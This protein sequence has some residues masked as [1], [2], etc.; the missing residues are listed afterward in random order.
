M[1]KPRP[2]CCCVCC[3]YSG[4]WAGVS[5]LETVDPSTSLTVRPFHGQL[6]GASCLS[7]WPAACARRAPMSSGHRPRALHNCRGEANRAAPLGRL[8]RP[9]PRHGIRAGP[10]RTQDLQPKGPAG[11][12]RRTA[13][14]TALSLGLL[15]D[16]RHLGTAQRFALEQDGRCG[17]AWAIDHAWTGQGARDTLRHVK[18]PWHVGS[19]MGAPHDLRKEALLSTTKSSMLFYLKAVPF[20]TDHGF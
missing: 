20:G 3:G 5:G 8:E 14:F 6:T 19:W 12:R 4:W 17:N 15:Q 11:D 9:P 13:P 16:L 18:P 1:G 7:R 2:L 10:V